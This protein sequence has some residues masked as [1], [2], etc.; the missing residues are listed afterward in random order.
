MVFQISN[1]FTL[2]AVGSIGAIIRREYSNTFSASEG[3]NSETKK[4]WVYHIIFFFLFSNIVMIVPLI[5]YGSNAFDQGYLFYC[6]I[7]IVTI[8]NSILN[9]KQVKFLCEN[10]FSRVFL[11]SIIKPISFHGIVFVYYVILGFQKLNSILYFL[12]FSLLIVFTYA[13]RETALIVNTLFNNLLSKKLDTVKLVKQIKE[14]YILTFSSL[15]M[16]LNFLLDKLLVPLFLKEISAS[17]LALTLGLMP[18]VVAFNAILKIFQNKYYTFRISYRSKEF[19]SILL[20]CSIVILVNALLLN[21]LFP[22]I[23][24]TIPIPKVKY[25]ILGSIIVFFNQILLFVTQW[26]IRR[27]YSSIV[28]WGSIYGVS[29]IFITSFMMIFLSASSFFL[30]ATIPLGVSIQ[31][32]FL[33]RKIHSESFNT[34]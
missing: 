16:E 15:L 3:L 12:V 13:W 24:P 23:F 5:F 31:I 6:L 18:S 17:Y 22:Y 27:R 19:C 29:T 2:F 4:L 1:F 14:G 10:A 7:V 30:L 33:V 8:T 11:N 9:L 26:F 20:F 21:Y 34:N 28:W 32:I 25:I